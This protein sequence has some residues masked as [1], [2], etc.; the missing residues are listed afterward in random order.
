M[1]IKKFMAS[2]G[3][4]PLDSI[5]SD[6][7]FFKIFRKV[8]CI[9]DSL[10]SG[11]FETYIENDVKMNYDMYEYSW[12][13]YMAREAGNTVFNFSKGG[14][15]AKEFY[16]SF[17]EKCGIW[18]EENICQAYIIALGVND[19][20]RDYGIGTIDDVKKNIRPWNF[21]TYLSSIIKIA[22]S[23]Q[24]EAKFFLMTTPRESIDTAHRDN[25]KREHASLLYDLANYYKNTYVLDLYK[26]APLYDDEFTKNFYLGNGHMNPQGYIL[27]AK[28]VMSY[29]DFII[30]NYPQDF[31]KTGFIGKPYGWYK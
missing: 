14:M 11:T 31:A 23:K 17:D 30:R 24:P 29:I 28:M 6:G 21:A 25:L 9:G 12:G 19:F 15:T 16:E 10:S 26:Y 18:A 5:V 1:D 3:E 13:Q 27:T 4:K 2:D 20:N 8:G 22:K 7:G